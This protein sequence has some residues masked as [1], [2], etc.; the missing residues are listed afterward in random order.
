MKEWI[1]EEQNETT[2]N[3]RTQTSFKEVK[4]LE[5]ESKKGPPPHGCNMVAGL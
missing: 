3:S 2:E 1:R 4:V 5:R